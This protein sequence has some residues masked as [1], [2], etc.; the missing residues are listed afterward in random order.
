MILYE[1][2]LCIMRTFFITPTHLG[3]EKQTPGNSERE[4]NAQYYVHH[5]THACL[6]RKTY[7]LS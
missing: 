1:A 6:L 5:Y 3:S 2:M 7:G 4:E